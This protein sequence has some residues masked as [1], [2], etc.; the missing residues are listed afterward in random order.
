[1]V[2]TEPSEKVRDYVGES[3]MLLPVLVLSGK[4][5]EKTDIWRNGKGAYEHPLEIVG[6]ECKDGVLQGFFGGESV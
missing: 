6:S 2:V 3:E 1:M 4:P 5:E